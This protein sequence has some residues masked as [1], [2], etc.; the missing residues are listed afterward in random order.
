MGPARREG[1]TV[2]IPGDYQARA[3]QSPRAV[4]R[5]WHQARLRLV[6]R[7]APPRPDGDAAD[8][9]CGSG[10]LS[11]YL[12]ARARRVVA[13]DSNPAAVAYARRAYGRPNL[14]FVLGQFERVLEVG[15]FDDFYCLEVIEH[16]YEAQA[17]ETLRMLRR[18]AKPGARLVL[19]TPNAGSAWPLVEA[20]LDRL[21]LAPRLAGEQHVTRFTSARLS[22]ACRDAGW[23]VVESGAFNGLAPFVAPLGEALALAVE[24]VEFRWRRRLP[25]NLLYCLCRTP[26]G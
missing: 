10:V 26:S 8:I 11:D 1:D 12:A 18:A 9:G 21:R 6:D 17:L 24:R 19:T 4:Q 2:A 20:A 23:T 22:R 16:L 13:I 7:L 3:L 14:E 25:L 15:P 5:F